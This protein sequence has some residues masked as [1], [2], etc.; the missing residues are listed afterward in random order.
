MNAGDGIIATAP[1]RGVAGLTALAIVGSLTLSGVFESPAVARWRSAAQGTSNAQVTLD[2][3]ATFVGEL[4]E[5]GVHW[6]RE[7]TVR[8]SP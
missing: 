8:G 7:C 5:V 4:D 1:R 3:E 6:R 2:C